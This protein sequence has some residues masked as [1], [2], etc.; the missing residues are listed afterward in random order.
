MR[1][2][3][4]EINNTKVEWVLH[5][6]DIKSGSSL[7]SDET[8]ISRFNLYAT[9]KPAFIYTPGDNE[10]TDCHRTGAGS[11]LP[12]ERLTR[13]RQI[14]FPV[15]GMT[16][17]GEPIQIATQAND[18][19]FPEFVENQLW[20]LKGVVFST[21]HVVGSNNNLAPWSGIDATDSSE[22]PRPDR[23]A[24][25]DRRLS[26]DLAWLDK[27]FALAEQTDAP[28]VFLLIHGDPEF[29]PFTGETS[30]EGFSVFLDVLREKTVTF[31]RPVVIAH[32]DSHFFRVDKLLKAPVA[33]QPGRVARIENF[34]R[35][36]TFGTEDVHWIKVKVD[37]RSPNVF[38]FQPMIV[39]ENLFPR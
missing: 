21:L 30:L 36:E 8:F 15:P 37:V 16:L 9:F 1:T 31:G 19:A 20:Q 5:A 17:G 13:L 25:Y 23:I 32:G 14:F 2:V 27:T 18:V 11:F 3:I 24:E 33:G 26:A 7:C 38:E 34:T 28:G 29:D 22:T 6:G 10:W 4:R 35:V 12:T 39:E